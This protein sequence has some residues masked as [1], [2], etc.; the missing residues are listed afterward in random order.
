ML[1]GAYW[2]S[3]MYG[4]NYQLDTV[5]DQLKMVLVRDCLDQVGTVCLDSRYGKTHHSRQQHPLG[6]DPRRLE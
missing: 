2:E 1:M 3:G 5:W 6:L 4:F